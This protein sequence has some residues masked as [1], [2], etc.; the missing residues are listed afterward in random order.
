MGRVSNVSV[1]LYVTDTQ[2]HQHHYQPTQSSSPRCLFLLLIRKEFFKISSFLTSEDVLQNID[3]FVLL[4]R[5]LFTNDIQLP[6]QNDKPCVLVH[7]AGSQ[8]PS[9][10]IL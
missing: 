4:L 3:W 1:L 5:A 9:S 2:H 7:I 10:I 6:D 8:F